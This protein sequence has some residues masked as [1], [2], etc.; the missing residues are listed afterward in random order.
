MHLLILEVIDEAND[1]ALIADI[2]EDCS[3]NP[4]GW[5]ACLYEAEIQTTGPPGNVIA[6]APSKGFRTTYNENCV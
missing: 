3:N 6:L 2:A 1:V 5:L 4:I